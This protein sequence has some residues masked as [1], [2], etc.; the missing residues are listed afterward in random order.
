MESQRSP[1]RVVA[2]PILK[3]VKKNGEIS[4]W[5]FTQMHYLSEEIAVV[6]V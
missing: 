1:N 2:Y 3:F 4:G 5:N 6:C